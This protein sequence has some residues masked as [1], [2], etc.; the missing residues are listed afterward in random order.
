MIELI[1][2]LE[3]SSRRIDK[4]VER[5]A[6]L[7]VQTNMLAVSGSVEAARAGDC[8]RGFAIVSADIRAL[9]RDSTDNADRIRDVVR[10]VQDQVSAVRRDLEAI[11]AAAQAEIGAQSGVGG[12]VRRRWTPASIAIRAGA[13]TVLRRGGSRLWPSVREVLA[14]T[15]QIA[16]AAEETSGAAAQ[17]ATAARQAGQRRGGPGRRHRGDRE[18]GRRARHHGG[19]SP[20]ATTPA[21]ATAC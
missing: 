7:A 9:A 5:I 4:I 21:T 10:S 6:L 20:V 1:G 13:A 2:S 3:S 14:G 8:G 12:A 16:A 15:T 18:P 19:L 11:A 17:A